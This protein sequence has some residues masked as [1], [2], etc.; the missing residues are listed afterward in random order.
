MKRHLI[1]LAPVYLL[2]TFIVACGGGSEAPPEAK[3]LPG[4]TKAGLCATK[5]LGDALKMCKDGVKDV[6]PLLLAQ[7]QQGGGKDASLALLLSAIKK[8]QPAPP[9]PP[10]ALS[11]DDACPRDEKDGDCGTNLTT[12]LLLLKA[13]QKSDGTMAINDPAYRKWIELTIRQFIQVASLQFKLNPM[14]QL[15]LGTQIT[16]ALNSGA[17]NGVGTGDLSVLNSYLNTPQMQALATQTQAPIY[18]PG[19]NGGNGNGMMAN[20]A[21]STPPTGRSTSLNLNSGSAT[22]SN[23]SLVTENSSKQNGGTNS[24]G[25]MVDVSQLRAARGVGL[26]S[27]SVTRSP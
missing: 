20:G 17:L 16:A 3:T 19:L 8:P 24:R 14:Q 4:I 13:T 5:R 23:K 10:A 21:V 27:S 2:F 12:S 7:Q 6:L 18:T 15:Y 25:Q 26:P 11:N 9:V 1:I 22:G